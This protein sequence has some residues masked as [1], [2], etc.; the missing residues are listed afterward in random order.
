M[1][2]SYFVKAFSLEIAG[3]STGGVG[4]SRPSKSRLF[5][6]QE[7]AVRTAL[8]HCS[9]DRVYAVRTARACA[10]DAPRSEVARRYSVKNSSYLDI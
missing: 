4:I 1:Q 10:S 5:E 9:F 7:I 6:G 8:N 2:N 3:Y